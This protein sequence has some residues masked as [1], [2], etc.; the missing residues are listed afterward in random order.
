[1][2]LLL[3]SVMIVNHTN[4]TVLSSDFICRPQ[5]NIAN[6]AR[7]TLWKMVTSFCLNSMPELVS[8][9]ART[10]RRNDFSLSPTSFSCI[11]MWRCEIQSGTCNFRLVINCAAMQA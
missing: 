4:V 7:H 5:E 8:Q 2:K 3:R 6:K 1:M 11:S 10:R 9:Q